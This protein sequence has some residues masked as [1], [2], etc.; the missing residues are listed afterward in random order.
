MNEERP[1]PQDINII[2][3]VKLVELSPG[4]VS[5]DVPKELRLT[6]EAFN[7][8]HRMVAEQ[9]FELVKLNIAE[10]HKQEVEGLANVNLVEQEEAK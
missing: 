5:V 9:G 10:I 3:N 2:L 4:K 6:P 1:I 7:F 8:I